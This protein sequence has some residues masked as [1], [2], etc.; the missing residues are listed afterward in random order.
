[1]KKKVLNIEFGSRIKELRYNLPKRDGNFVYQHEIAKEAGIS[2]S[3]Y[4]QAEAG[5]IPGRAVL[6]ALSEY[7]N[8]PKKYVIGY[9][10]KSGIV[11]ILF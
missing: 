5:F 3:S 9:M 2:V 11:I 7:F 4:Q 6:T 8:K 10:I 1:M